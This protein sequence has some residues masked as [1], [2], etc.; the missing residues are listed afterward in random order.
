MTANPNIIIVNFILFIL[1]NF[2]YYFLKIYFLFIKITLNIA[3]V[4]LYF[5][6]LLLIKYQYIFYIN[7]KI[8]LL[9]NF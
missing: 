8:L 3:L 5:N 2:V 4:L 1:S 9:F 6:R 7:L